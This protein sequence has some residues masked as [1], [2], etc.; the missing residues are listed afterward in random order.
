MHAAR[1]ALSAA[2]SALCLLAAAPHGAAQCRIDKLSASAPTAFSTFGQS[3]AI[4]G[5][6]M[7]VGSPFLGFSNG[8]PGGAYVYVHGPTGW[9]FQQLLA[10]AGATDSNDFGISVAIDG[11]TILV[12]ADTVGGPLSGA[13]GAVY[14]FTWDGAQWNQVQAFQA[15]D[16]AAGGFFG[17]SV[18]LEGDTA[19]VGRWWDSGPATHAGSAYVF[20]RSGGAFTQAAKLTAGDPR[21]EDMFGWSVALSGAR[22]AV[23]AP[24]RFLMLPHDNQLGRVFVFTGAGAT[25]TQTA[26]LVSS[27]PL[28]HGQLGIS[29]DLDGEQLIA[30]AFQDVFTPELSGNGAAYVYDFAGG[31]WTQSQKLFATD[32]SLEDEFGL[33]V[34][35][36]GS[37]ILV[38]APSRMASFPLWGG[39]YAFHKDGASWVQKQLFL[40]DAT[41]SLAWHGNA[42]ALDGN[43]GAAG[44]YQESFVADHSGSLYVYAGFHAFEDLGSGLAG[45]AGV[46]QL[47][48]DGTL[49]AGTMG[50]LALSGAVPS[51]STFLVLGLRAASAPFKGG[52]LV[53]APEVVLAGLPLSAGGALA[54]PFTWPS[55][56]PSGAAFHAQCWTPDAAAVQGFS[57][58]NAVKGSAP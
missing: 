34:A 2:L 19:V 33:A 51:G 38:G 40:P 43:T 27:P 7:I 53:P 42:V 35:I 49:C 36:E 37:W 23:G 32:G 52:T 1:H 11:D 10:A 30:G 41:G 6:R 18:A 13:V 44:A 54:L 31:A 28:P 12:G 17:G 3:V 58:S 14:V 8:G 21:P 20:T 39:V 29:V 5:D 24:D 16:G 56:V 48:G 25:W 57:A 9:E 26:K 22:I 46:P 47:A 45:V 55:G 50:T 15:S 4:S